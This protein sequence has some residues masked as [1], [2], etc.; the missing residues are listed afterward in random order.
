MV[1]K[2]QLSYRL[3]RRPGQQGPRPLSGDQDRVEKLVTGRNNKQTRRNNDKSTTTPIT[4]IQLRKKF[5]IGTWN[6]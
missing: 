4:S 6:V 1:N 3:G 2:K 5:R